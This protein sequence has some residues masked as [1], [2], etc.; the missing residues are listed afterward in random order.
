M[1]SKAQQ[2]GNLGSRSENQS[3]T[4]YCAGHFQLFFLI[5]LSSAAVSFLCIQAADEHFLA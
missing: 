5:V 4:A 2:G 3:R 1:H